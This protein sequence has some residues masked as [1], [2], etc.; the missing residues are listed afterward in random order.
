MIT[1]KQDK[2]LFR[3]LSNFDIIEYGKKKNISIECVAKDQLQ[4]IKPLKNNQ[5]VVINLDDIDSNN[6]GTH[7]V[8]LLYKKKTMFYYDPFGITDIAPDI[9]DYI[10]RHKGDCYTSSEQNQH[11]ESNKCGWF[12]LAIINSCIGDRKMSY[13]DYMDMLYNMPQPYNEYVIFCLI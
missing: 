4:Q 10:K 9:L 1:K 2:E 12:C 3:P 6:G 7:W 8:C 11:I 5:S 13:Q